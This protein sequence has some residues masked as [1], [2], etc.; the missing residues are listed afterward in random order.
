MSEEATD[1]LIERLKHINLN[2]FPFVNDTCWKSASLLASQ[3]EEIDIL[4]HEYEL[5][6]TRYER[7]KRNV[8]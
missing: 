4:K 6:M 8:N 2:D 3:R 1:E 7:C 5:L